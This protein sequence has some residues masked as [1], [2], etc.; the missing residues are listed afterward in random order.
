VDDGL[1]ISQEKTFEKSNTMLFCSY[2]TII[3][4]VGL[5]AEY[6]KSEI[7]HFPRLTK[8]FYSPLLDLTSLGE[9]IL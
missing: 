4:L 9:P 2:N 3:S 7:F 8:N 5:T 6:R 1:F